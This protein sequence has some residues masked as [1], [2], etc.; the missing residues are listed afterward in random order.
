MKKWEERKMNKCV[1]CKHWKN[2]LPVT[3]KYSIDCATCVK[4]SIVEPE[5]GIAGVFDSDDDLIE[6]GFLTGKDFGCIHFESK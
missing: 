1:D 3:G 4:L 2:R 6:D 5:S